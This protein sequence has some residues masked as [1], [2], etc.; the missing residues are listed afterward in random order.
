MAFEGQDIHFYARILRRFELK[1]FFL[2]KIIFI[3]IIARMVFSGKYYLN[4]SKE[5]SV[6]YVNGC[7]CV[8]RR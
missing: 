2:T 7:L 3:E 1:Y 5:S 8:S 6:N 4:S